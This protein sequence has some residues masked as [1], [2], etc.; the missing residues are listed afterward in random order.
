[1]SFNTTY[2]LILI[3]NG[4]YWGTVFEAFCGYSVVQ[5][6]TD[7]SVITD[8]HKK[9]TH[10]KKLNRKYCPRWRLISHKLL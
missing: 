6:G 10:N 1:M 5:C 2:E 8:R 3:E 7:V 4:S 9:T